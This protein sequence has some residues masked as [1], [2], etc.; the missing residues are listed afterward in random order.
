MVATPTTP[1]PD[2]RFAKPGVYPL[3]AGRTQVLGTLEY[4]SVRGSAPGYWICALYPWESKALVPLVKIV[5]LGERVSYSSA[6]HF[7]SADGQLAGDALS[8]DSMWGVE[9]DQLSWRRARIEKPNQTWFP[10]KRLRAVG[11][12]TYVEG[13]RDVLTRHW[14]VML[15]M[16]GESS[17][18]SAHVA[19]FLES[20]PPASFETSDPPYV[21]VE[22]DVV[23]SIRVSGTPWPVVRTRSISR[24][25]TTGPA[26]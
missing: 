7:V 16:P 22:G 5:H 8:V 13:Y 4:G 9:G 1:T 24:V 12:L 2:A 23:G 11:L 18:G 6:G 14:A 17:Y 15:A 3:P 20:P 19:A 26:R 10:G 25:P 21:A